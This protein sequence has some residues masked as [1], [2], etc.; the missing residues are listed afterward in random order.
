[1]R[2]DFEHLSTRAFGNHGDVTCFKTFHEVEFK[3]APFQLTPGLDA[4]L[5]EFK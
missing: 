1:L 4:D 2:D 5:L 3:D